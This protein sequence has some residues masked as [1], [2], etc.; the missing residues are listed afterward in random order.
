MPAP[1]RA[2]SLVFP[3][4]GFGSAGT[5]LSREDEQVAVCGAVLQLLIPDHRNK[6]FVNLCKR[7][8]HPTDGQTRL[9]DV[10]QL[11][12]GRQLLRDWAGFGV[13][14][15]FFIKTA[16]VLCSGPACEGPRG[17]VHVLSLGRPSLSCHSIHSF[18]RCV[19]RTCHRGALFD[20]ELG[21]DI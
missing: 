19:L 2:G 13:L 9:R 6:S 3:D 4:P 18:S 5:S 8:S 16:F 17:D 20:A 12:Q 10:G 1:G 21:H 14:V 11:A 15:S 7:Y